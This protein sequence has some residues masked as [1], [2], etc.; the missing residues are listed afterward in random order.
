MSLQ[1]YLRPRLVVLQPSASAL[2]A[3]RAIE[4]NKI[5]AVII[6]DKGS[7]VGLLTDRDLAVRLV[8]RGLDAK[9][10]TIGE[11]MTT[12]LATLSSND[13]QADA[14]ALMRERNIRRIPLV[15]D[16]K[17]VGMV[18]LDD[19]LLD[20]AAPLEELA[21]I[22]QVQLGEG[23]PAPTRRAARER[24][25]TRA[26]STYRRFLNHVRASSG[27]DAALA[28]TAVQTVLRSLVRRL[29][30]GEAKDLIAQLPSLLHRQLKSVP[31]GPDKLVTRETMESELVQRLDIDPVRAALV[32]RAIGLTLAQVVSPG[33]IDD[34]HS[35]LPEVLRFTFSGWPPSVSR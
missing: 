14:I 7:P 29:D 5:G 34:M 3:A 4:N 12:P 15:D 35:Q 22:V 33:Q 32:L 9:T 20:E 17:L 1:W 25:G 2:E 10:T 16:G 11:I 18:T 21:A 31:P 23:G 6:A 13:S 19:L 27:L 30:P 8:G 26:E 24:R 28:E